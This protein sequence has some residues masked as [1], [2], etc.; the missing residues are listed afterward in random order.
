[1]SRSPRSTAATLYRR[2]P[3]ARIAPGFD[4]LRLLPERFVRKS[5]PG[6]LLEM[7]YVL[8]VWIR[9]AERY[10]QGHASS[11]IGG[12]AGRHVRRRRREGTDRGGAAGIGRSGG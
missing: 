3:E 4:K 5:A 2:V 8:E 12:V 7:I 11:R 10:H 6:H 1:P 9:N